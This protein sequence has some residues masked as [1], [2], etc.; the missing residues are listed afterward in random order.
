M[1]QGDMFVS[2]LKTLSELTGM[3]MLNINMRVVVTSG[4]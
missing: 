4:L 1:F 3:T 2:C